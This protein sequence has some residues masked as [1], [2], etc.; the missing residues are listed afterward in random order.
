MNL[1]IITSVI[2]SKKNFFSN[3]ERFE[4]LIYKTIPSILNKIPNCYL[5]LLEGSRINNEQM[6]I[7]KKLTNE[8]VQYETFEFEKSYGELS[9]ISSY[10]ESESF[11]YIENKIDNLI[12]ISGRYF[13][14]DDFDFNKKIDE[15]IIKKDHFRKVCETRYYKVVNKYIQK[16]K[17]EISNL[18]KIGIYLDLEHTFYHY[19]VIST[20]SE[21]DRI[22][23]GGY[24]APNG[25]YIED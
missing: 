18:R 7:L 5:V 4:Q 24:L 3:E 22:F 19:D 15:N 20:V 25:L 6:N 1:V 23:L 21:I 13:L 12:K 2:N 9:L 16:F 14:L 8:I 11:S 10:L 17:N